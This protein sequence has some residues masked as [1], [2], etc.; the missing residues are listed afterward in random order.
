MSD[1]INMVTN[2]YKYI[3]NVYKYCNK[4][5]ITRLNSILTEEVIVK[6]LQLFTQNTD[7]KREL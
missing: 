1:N 2:V 7:L 4:C 5:L 3:I 6:C